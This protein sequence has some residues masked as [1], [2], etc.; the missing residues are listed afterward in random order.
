VIETLR[1]EQPDYVIIDSLASWGKWGARLVKLPV[2]GFFSTFVLDQKSMPPIPPLAL[3][4]LAYN[5]MKVTPAYMGAASRLRKTHGVK[6][7]GLISALMTEGDFN[8]VFTSS[9]FQPNAAAFD[10]RFRFVGPSLGSRAGG[11]FP[12]EQLSRQPVI[13]ISLGT[14][15]NQNTDFYRQCFEAFA[16]H[17]GRVVLSVGKATA[18][19]SLGAIPDN[20]IVRN[21]V[22]QLQVLEHADLF[23]THGGLNSVHEGLM[24]NVPLVVVPQQP[25]QGIV[26]NQVVKHGAGVALTP[27]SSS[28]TAEALRAAAREVLNNSAYRE[29]SGRLGESLRAAGGATRAAEEILTFTRRSLLM[30]A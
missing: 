16:D 10:N 14:I 15:N 5:V 20:F 25:E 12:F 21:F 8:V 1:R 24:A 28:V 11:D 18:I 7:E 17:T 23:I 13:Y 6:T 19:E 30:P 22:P 9:A 4:R 29:N 27:P 26:A 2:V 3:V